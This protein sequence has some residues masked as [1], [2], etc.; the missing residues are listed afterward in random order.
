L[1]AIS[2]HFDQ[3]IFSGELY[4]LEKF[5]A[6]RKYYKNTTSLEIKPFLREKLDDYKTID[7]FRLDVNYLAFYNL[8]VF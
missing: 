7:D 4:G 3:F 5:W 1:A 2:L 8:I 6:F